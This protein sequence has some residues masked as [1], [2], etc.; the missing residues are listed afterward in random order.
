MWSL[1]QP[2]G[3][4]PGRAELCSPGHGW[5]PQSSSLRAT[6]GPS[7][8]R[9]GCGGRW[10]EHLAGRA[11]G[12]LEGLGLEPAPRAPPRGPGLLWAWGSWT[13]CREEAGRAM[14]SVRPPNFPWAPLDGESPERPMGADGGAQEGAEGMWG[15]T[16]RKMPGALGKREVRETPT[17][18]APPPPSGG[19]RGKS[20]TWFPLSHPQH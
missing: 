11:G 12:G 20:Q 14:S 4:H 3:H 1:C 7:A 17:E 6:S 9:T 15:Q 2:E 10:T 8:A 13:V 19:G 16:Y 18:E 5:Q